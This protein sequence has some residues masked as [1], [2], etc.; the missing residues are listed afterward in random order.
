MFVW[1]RTPDG[2]LSEF[3]GPIS[4]EPQKNPCW[5]SVSLHIYCHLFYFLSVTGYT[6]PLSTHSACCFLFIYLNES[7]L[8]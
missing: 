6:A 4:V 1:F 5:F 3:L 8:V 2:T 7:G